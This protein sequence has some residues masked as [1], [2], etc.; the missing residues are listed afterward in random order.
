MSL[1]LNTQHAIP[2]A[3]RAPAP[4]GDDAA[5]VGSRGDSTPP[6]MTSEGGL[7]LHH[8]T[9]IVHARDGCT[10]QRV[11]ESYSVRRLVSGSLQPH[12]PCR[13]G[14]PTR[15]RSGIESFAIIDAVACGLPADSEFAL[16]RSP[17]QGH[18]RNPTEVWQS[19]PRLSSDEGC[20]LKTGDEGFLVPACLVCGAAPPAGR[21]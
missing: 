20:E 10:S 9:V 18:F 1:S 4:G 21:R 13:I 17:R 12:P 19:C 11:A 15:H 7:S 5:P 8:R 16:P 3:G 6:G 14:A 2:L